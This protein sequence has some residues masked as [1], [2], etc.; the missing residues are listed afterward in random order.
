MPS[1]MLFGEPRAAGLM[2]IWAEA[3]SNNAL[4]GQVMGSPRV[5]E[6]SFCIG[7][8]KGR[9]LFMGFPKVREKTSE[10]MKKSSSRRDGQ[11]SYRALGRTVERI[12]NYGEV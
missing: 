4:L 10:K 11:S 12:G 6:P 7:R 9:F 8:G 3:W 2:P 1:A 5:T